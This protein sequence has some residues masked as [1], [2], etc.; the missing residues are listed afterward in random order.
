MA[1][2]RGDMLTQSRSHVQAQA[3]PLWTH[4]NLSTV[5][6]ASRQCM[7]SS[8]S[9]APGG[10]SE[11]V[12]RTEPRIRCSELR[13]ARHR[14]R[15]LVGVHSSPGGHARRAAIR[16]TWMR[17]PSVGRTTMVCFL[18]GRP[19][20]ND[21][22]LT[23]RLRDESNRH[24]DMIFLDVVE[25][26]KLS[27]A[28]ALAFWRMA[29]D[30]VVSSTSTA[31]ATR[32]IGAEQRPLFIA[33]TDDDAVLNLPMLERSL[34][35]VSCVPYLYYGAFAFT[36]YDTV[37]F[38]NCGFS[39]FGFAAY[40]RYGC[41]QRPGMAPPFP[42]ALGQLQ[43]ISPQLVQLL[44]SSALTPA[45]LAASEAK[46][47]AMFNAGNDGF[48]DAVIGLLL[49]RSVE[50]A[51]VPH[52][53]SRPAVTSAQIGGN[54]DGGRQGNRVPR[55][56]VRITRVNIGARAWHNLGCLSNTGMFRQ[57]GA[58]SMVVHGVRS[59][60][61]MR[62][63]SRLLGLQGVPSRVT[64]S[65]TV[66]QTGAGRDTIECLDS[67]NET[68]APLER[69]RSWCERCAVPSPS[70]LCQFGSGG[71]MRGARVGQQMALARASCLRHGLL[72]QAG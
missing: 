6:Q 67:L 33:K 57:P 42:F 40:Q 55:K 26:G 28:K 44:A 39:W 53:G 70:A 35:Q 14:T 31:R 27:I 72:R 15:L 51:L 19:L 29:A 5:K 1:S 63:V 50:L 65:V 24:G 68:E 13:S 64:T 46:A 61:A 49:H 20:A 30:L 17:W 37:R 3:Y 32:A 52:R 22:W 66:A 16:S 56:G 8:D 48:E 43:V 11:H 59:A 41:E 71:R 25:R 60:A 18:I 36:G 21:Q 58:S 9:L 62:Y 12:P 2:S 34:A 69:M 47:T 45:F 54:N 10:A 38:S 4:R 7:N 23:R